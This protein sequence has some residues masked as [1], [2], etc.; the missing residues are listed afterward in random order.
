MQ[1]A[2]A[3][4]ELA[5]TTAGALTAEDFEE[6]KAEESATYSEPHSPQRI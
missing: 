3:L 2:R 5:S 1:T 4:L 6:R